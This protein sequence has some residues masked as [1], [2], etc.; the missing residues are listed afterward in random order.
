M[1]EALKL[2]QI[3]LIIPATNATSERSFSTL[4]RIKS[5]LK[6]SMKQSRLNHLITF[7]IY[8]ERLDELDMKTIANTFVQA[9]ESR[10]TIFGLFK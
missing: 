3:L 9:N 8:K 10:Q 4:R 5:Y 6:S 2:V 1:K 7:N